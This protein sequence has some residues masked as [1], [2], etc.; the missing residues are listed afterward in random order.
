MQ[1]ILNRFLQKKSYE[2]LNMLMYIAQEI[3]TWACILGDF[4]CKKLATSYL[5]QHLSNRTRNK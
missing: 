3:R 1:K 2:K 5:E 4:D